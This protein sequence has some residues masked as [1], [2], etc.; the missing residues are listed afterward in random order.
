[1]SRTVR[2]VW[3]GVA[4]AAIGAATLGV[5]AQARIDAAGS[6]LS[7]LAARLDATLRLVAARGSVEEARGTLA[8]RLRHA[9]VRGSRDA[10]VARFLRD[11]SAIAARHHTA[12]GA[13]TAAATIAASAA[14]AAAGNRAAASIGPSPGDGFDV[15]PLELTVEGRYADLL[16]TMRDVSAGAV[17]ARVELVTLARKDGGSEAAALEATLRTELLRLSDADASPARR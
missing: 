16:A 11:A 15:V 5:L 10:I 9:G 12:I 2:G 14:T 13:V 4:G 6:D 7:V 17:P 8:G 1:M 3:V